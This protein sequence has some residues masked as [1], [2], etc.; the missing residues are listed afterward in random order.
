MSTYTPP[1]DVAINT[2]GGTPNG[3]MN[4]SSVN[5]A[6]VLSIP[7]SGYNNV[8]GRMIQQSGKSFNFYPYIMMQY[9]NLVEKNKLTYVTGAYQ[10]GMTVNDYAEI[11]WNRTSSSNLH[12]TSNQW[13]TH[14]GALKLIA[15]FEDSSFNK[16]LPGGAVYS[17]D[18]KGSNQI[19]QVNSYQTILKG[20]G[21][22]QVGYNQTVPEVLK[23]AHA[24]ATH[25]AY[26]TTV[27]N[28]LEQLSMEQYVSTEAAQGSAF[29]SGIEVGVGMDISD[30]DN[31]STTASGDDK[32]Y[33]RDDAGGLNSAANEYDLDVNNKG[34]K[35]TYYTFSSDVAGNIWMKAEGAEN[36][37]KKILGQTDTIDNLNDARA[38]MLDAR[39]GVVTKLLAA[40]ERN[41]GN[42]ENSWAESNHWYNEAFNGITV[43]MY[44]TTLELGF[45][46]PSIRS[47]VLD[48]KLIPQQ[49]SKGTIFQ[50][51]FSSQFRTENKG[52][53]MPAPNILGKFAGQRISTKNLESLFWSNKFYIPDANVQDLS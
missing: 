48:P 13:T 16:I 6:E 31:G 2:Y 44:Q 24:T 28:T 43:V 11:A 52:I 51:V 3:G 32:Y 50:Q 22:E 4:D 42:D 15:D 25:E 18:T 7:L 17:L 10:R 45:H 27:V 1:I 53:G 38:Q 9:D 8:T 20:K 35:V 34:T 21:L 14:A 46:D 12:V 23:E 5:T 40:L 37:N 49:V 19:M 29:D 26:V 39:T 36:Y 33:F 30:L 47:T 41:T